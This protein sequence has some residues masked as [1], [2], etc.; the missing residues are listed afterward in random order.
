MPNTKKPKRVTGLQLVS[1][2]QPNTPQGDEMTLRVEKL[3]ERDGIGMGVL[4]DGTAFLTGRGLARLCGV[5]VSVIAELLAHWNHEAHK[6]RITKIKEIL[7]GHGWASESP[8]IAVL[9]IDQTLAYAWPDPVCLAILEYYAFDAQQGD[10]EQARRNYRTLAGKAL[11]DFIYTEVGYD[12]RHQIQEHWRIFHDRVSL[13]YSSV[14]VGYF[15]IIK[16]IA[17]M[18]VH[19]GQNG[20]HIDSSFI[21]DIS[22]GLIWGKH[23]TTNNFDGTYGVRLKFDHNYPEYFPQAKSNPQ[24]IW[25]YPQVALGEFRKWFRENYIG[26]GKFANYLTNAVK[27]KE[28]PASFAQRAIAAYAQVRS[29]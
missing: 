23:W 14:P 13:T 20:V 29:Q 7:G 5:S 6:P 22:V 12:P 4:S 27:K 1:V 28:L 9:E 21:P 18:V 15:C 17:E 11:H 3:V 8:V 26:D 10:R 16:E 2:V 25:C 19:L 24:D